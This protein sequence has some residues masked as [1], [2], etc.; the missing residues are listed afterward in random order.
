LLPYHRFDRGGNC[1]VLNVERLLAKRVTED[2]A[3][4]L[5]R[6][7]SDPALELT[8]AVEHE[9][10]ELKLRRNSEWEQR[11]AEVQREL[12]DPKEQPISNISLF[13]SQ[14]CNMRCVYCYG[15]GGEYGDGSL[16]EEAAATRA[17]DWLIEQSE[18][19]KELGIT[20][21]GGEPL[22]NFPLVRRV[23][24]YASG[25]GSAEGKTFRFGLTTNLSILN[26]ETI[27]F[28]RAH[29]FSVLVSFDG[30]PDVQDRNRPFRDGR[31]SYETVAANVRRLLS[32]LP[33]GRV[34]CR[35]TLF[36]ATDPQ[37][38]VQ[39]IRSFGFAT[40]HLVPRSRCI[41]ES[42][43]GDGED[44]QD[45][46]RLLEQVEA[47][48][49]EALT[50]IRTRD[51]DGIKAMGGSGTVAPLLQ[52]IALRRRRFYSCGAGRRYV[53]IA[54]SGDVFLCHRF[55][56]LH[57]YRLGSIFDGALDRSAYQGSLIRDGSPCA[58]CWARYFCAGLC[59]YAN[60]AATGDSRRPAPSP[61]QLMKRYLEA[62]IR[63]WCDLDDGDR[64]YFKYVHL[65]TG[66][67]ENLAF[68]PW[69]TGP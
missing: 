38:V 37:R 3:A 53:A 48:A 40:W 27:A 41:L 39:A 7:T 54:T 26:H 19:V 63:A 59:R 61:C 28:L 52:D 62:A 23:V 47:D 43:M 58:P 6:L 35:A 11:H 32:A 8:S 24:E 50:V 55:V 57:E 15:G 31:G 51:W 33:K 18:G 29:E 67:K 46:T 68:E 2:A 34:A 21:F 12:A 65:L 36:G 66:D 20:F 44:A 5:D 4:T 69:K 1:Y 16:M 25:R 45:Q 64:K 30:P 14:Q 13:V 17:V 10:S 56:G 60:A 49:A 9:L 42:G 22:L